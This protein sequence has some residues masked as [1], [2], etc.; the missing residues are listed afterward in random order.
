[1]CR[2]RQGGLGGSLS[3]RKLEAPAPVPPAPVPPPCPELT[4]AGSTGSPREA[5]S[6]RPCRSA[7]RLNHFASLYDKL[8][9]A[10]RHV[11]RSCSSLPASPVPSCSLGEGGGGRH[12]Q[13]GPGGES[14]ELR[15]AAR[16]GE[17][18]PAGGT[19]SSSRTPANS[20]STALIK[21][22]LDRAISS[23]RLQLCL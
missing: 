11:E 23:D 19:G 15:G 21:G 8:I 6:A 1:M 10:R 18:E 7:T 20:C 12:V 14:A 3:A 16:R 22:F 4:D 17:R 9:R 2:P 13:R 5:F